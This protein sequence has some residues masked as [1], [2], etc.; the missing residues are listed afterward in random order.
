MPDKIVHKG[1]YVAISYTILDDQGNVL[2]QHDLPIGFVFGSDTQLIGN[3]DKL[4]EGKREGDVLEASIPP[5]EAF[6]PHDP[7]LTF[8]D[9]VENVPPE[10][11]RVGAEVAMQNEGGDSRTFYVTRIENGQLT[12]DGNHPLA[13]KTLTVRVTIKEVRDARPGEDKVS[14]IHAVQ[15]QGP[16]SI[17]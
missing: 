10:F 17:N 16:S 1:K 7:E 4:V 14:G 2:E 12:V 6:G 3:M 8:T 9:D 11:R 15:M 5:D 13:G